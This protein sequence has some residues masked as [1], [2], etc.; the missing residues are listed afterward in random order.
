MWSEKYRIYIT[1]SNA[2]L[3]S[4]DLATLFTGRTFEIHVFPFSFNEFLAYFEDARKDIYAAFDVFVRQGR[5]SG[6][7]L[8]QQEREKYTW[9]PLKTSVFRDTHVYYERI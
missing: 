4:S 9:E 2:F 6:S 3:L 5:M 8:Y 7:Y 1:G